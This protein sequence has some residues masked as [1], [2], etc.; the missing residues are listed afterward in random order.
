MSPF[1]SLAESCSTMYSP[2][3]LLL[4]HPCKVTEVWEEA[5]AVAEAR[6]TG[7]RSTLG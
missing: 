5:K 7:Q 3:L 4:L 6:V 2:V 1:I